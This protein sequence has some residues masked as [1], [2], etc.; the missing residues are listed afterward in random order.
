MSGREGALSHLQTPG[1]GLQTLRVRRGAAPARA[2][3]PT[4]VSCW[5]AGSHW[6][7][8]GPARPELGPVPPTRR[9]WQAGPRSQRHSHPAP[10]ARDVK[11]GVASPLKPGNVLQ[12]PQPLA[13]STRQDGAGPSL[14]AHE[15]LKGSAEASARAAPSPRLTPPERRTQRVPSTGHPLNALN[16]QQPQLGLPVAGRK[17]SQHPDTGPPAAWGFLHRTNFGVRG[18]GVQRASGAQRAPP[19]HG[20]DPLVPEPKPAHGTQAP[21]AASPRA[22]GR[23]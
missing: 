5:R 19:G 20:R 18:L 17:Q 14:R 13:P 15:G 22:S 1:Q 12:K 2:R 4:P 23:L 11:R 10:A 9:P 21:P 3:G 16:S 7:D 8:P 6:P